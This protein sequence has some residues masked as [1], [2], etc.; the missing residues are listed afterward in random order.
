[1]ARLTTGKIIAKSLIANGDDTV[2]GIPGAR[3]S[4]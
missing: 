3:R 4:A 1:M 2:F